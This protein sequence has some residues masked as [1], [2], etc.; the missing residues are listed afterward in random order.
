MA[1]SDIDSASACVRFSNRRMASR[2]SSRRPKRDLSE[3]Q[4][5]LYAVLEVSSISF[6][7]SAAGPSSARV[8]CWTFSALVVQLFARATRSKCSLNDFQDDV[9]LYGLGSCN[10]FTTT[11][12]TV[13]A[14]VVSA[15]QAVFV[16]TVVGGCTVVVSVKLIVVAAVD[17][18]VG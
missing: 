4:M 12:G 10:C 9:L 3:A 11:V 14:D 2:G 8:N 16:V 5:S 18:L 6:K 15:E 13:T 1:K 17:E 7:V